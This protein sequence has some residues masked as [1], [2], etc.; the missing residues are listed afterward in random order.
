MSDLQYQPRSC[1]LPSDHQGQDQAGL[2]KYITHGEMIAARART[3]SRSR[4]ADR[5][6]ALSSFGDKQQ[7]GVGQ[8]E[9]KPGDPVGQGQPGQERARAR[10]AIKPGDH[11]L[12]VD[13]TLQEL[14][15]ILGER[16]GAAATSSPRAQEDRR[17]KTDKYTGISQRRARI[18][19]V[20]S[21]VPL[22]ETL[23][24]PDRHGHLQP[25]EPDHHPD[26]RGQ[27]L[28]LAGRRER[29]PRAT[30][31]IIYMMDVSGS[32]GDE[33]KEIVRTESFWIDTWLRSPVQGHR[34]PL[35]HP[36][37]DR[38]RSGRERSSAPARAAA[39]SSARPTSLPEDHRDG[40]SARRSGTSIRFT[41]PTATTGRA[42]TRALCM[43][44]LEKNL[45]PTCNVFCYGQVESPLR[46]GPVHQ[47]S[48]GA[49]RRRPRVGDSFED[50]EQGGRSC[51]RS[52]IS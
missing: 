5:H 49:I 17:A 39:R 20:T 9:G 12:E 45:L 13:L 24:T 10:R 33:Q 16:A 15:E 2:K 31:V 25:E 51:S 18:R 34:D 26:P 38:A 14:A 42:R 21:S 3:R 1:P 6:P 46:L 19:C 47:G 8:G 11:M 36:R 50:Q 37:R 27:A 44:L 7:G 40:L 23:Q 35:H 43:E 52:R 28:S 48:E 30:R 29:P 22:Q 4:A 32:M 41:S